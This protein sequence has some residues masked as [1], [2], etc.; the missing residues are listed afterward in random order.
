MGVGFLK[1]NISTIVG[2]LYADNDPRRDSG[3]S[4]F[5][6]GINLGALFAS[7]VCGYLGETYGWKYGFGAAGIGMLLGLAHVPVGPE[8]P[9]RPR[10]TADA[11]AAARTR[12]RPAARVADLRCGA[13]LGAAAGGVR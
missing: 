6:A 4:L 10:R 5:Y 2:K 8:V 7:L 13:L 1:P 9:A 3:F 12:V 11:R